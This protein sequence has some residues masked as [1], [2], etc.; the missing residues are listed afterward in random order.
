MHA[1]VITGQGTLELREFPEPEPA[2]GG[3]VVDVALCGVCGTDVHA[4]AHGG[5]YPA[6][7]CGHEWTGTVSAVGADVSTL[8]EGDRVVVGILPSCGRCVDCRAG[9]EEV[10]VAA[11]GSLA[12][13]PGGSPHG[14]YGPRIAASA[15][16]VVPAHPGLSDEVAALVEP[17]TVAFHGVRR[18][19]GLTLG[20]TVVVQGAGP[21]GAFALQ[22]ARVHGAGH[23]IVIEPGPERRALAS[24]LG[25]DVVVE[26]GEAALAEVQERTGGL[27]ADVVFE[28]AGVPVAIQSAID[29]VR[30]GGQVILIGLSDLPATIHPTLWNAKEVEVRGS[31]AYRR[32]EFDLVMAM[33]ADGR[34]AAAPL[35]T[36]TVGLDGL[37]GALALLAA[38]AP[39]E[40]KVLL[41]PR[42]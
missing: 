10:C 28:C 33:L 30:R 23:V 37:D 31:I 3:V 7:L 32:P 29:L 9:H 18:A 16:R 24:T 41:D 11:M 2:P 21:I 19:S 4:Y 39:A 13:D 25:A 5:A 6:T 15:D 42:S 40:S 20:A 27:G 34:I 1:A 14:A 8:H 17:A 26:P 22:W 35:H 36:S 12:F 38:G